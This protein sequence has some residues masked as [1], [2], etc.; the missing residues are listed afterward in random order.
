MLEINLKD[1]NTAEFIAVARE[2]VVSICNTNE[3][4]CPRARGRLKMKLLIQCN[5]LVIIRY[6]LFEEEYRLGLRFSSQSDNIM[7]RNN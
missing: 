2:E 7:I 4:E 1:E 5:W 3:S 6:V